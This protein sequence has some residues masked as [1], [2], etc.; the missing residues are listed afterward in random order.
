MVKHRKNCLAWVRTIQAVVQ[1]KQTKYTTI[2]KKTFTVPH[3]LF[4]RHQ[5]TDTWCSALLIIQLLNKIY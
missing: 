5:N 3:F 2:K 1:T 4:I